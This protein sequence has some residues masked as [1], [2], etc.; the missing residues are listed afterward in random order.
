[1]NDFLDK[2]AQGAKDLT[3]SAQKQLESATLKSKAVAI[4]RSINKD[5]Q[6]MGEMAFLAIQAGEAEAIP[7][8]VEELTATIRGKFAEADELDKKVLALGEE[9]MCPQ[10]QKS[11]PLAAQFCSA[12]GYKF[13]DAVVEE[14]ADEEVAV[15]KCPSCGSPLEQGSGYCGDCGTKLGL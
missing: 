9:K 13:D 12:C 1:M 7:A 15:E 4:R 6:V 3:K 8:R 14:E 5:Y 10:C 11:C 2:I